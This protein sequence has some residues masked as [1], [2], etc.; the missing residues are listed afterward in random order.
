MEVVAQMMEV[1]ECFCL[2][3]AVQH[4][5]ISDH[6]IAEIQQTMLSE[7]DIAFA[8]AAEKEIE[9]DIKK[10]LFCVALDGDYEM[11]KCGTSSESPS[12]TEPCSS[13]RT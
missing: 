9:R 4:L 6:D 10:K 1:Y 5:C 8:I 13:S 12:T 11:A 3:P 7:R 2:L